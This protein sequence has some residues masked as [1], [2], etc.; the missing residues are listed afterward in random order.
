MP[1]FYFILIR[2]KSLRVRM[3]HHTNGALVMCMTEHGRWTK[4]K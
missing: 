1:K 4:A 3:M 2:M